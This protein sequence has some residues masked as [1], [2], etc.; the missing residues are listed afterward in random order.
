MC[1]RH[2]SCTAGAIHA[3][4]LAIHARV[5]RWAISARVPRVVNSAL[6]LPTVACM[7]TTSQSHFAKARVLGVYAHPNS[8][9]RTP[10]SELRICVSNAFYLR[11]STK[12][13]AASA[14]IAPSAHAV[15]TC[16]I[17]FLRQSP[18]TKI[19]FVFVVQASSLSA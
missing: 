15:A 12:S 19:P 7:A 11:L 17:L 3:S 18:A 16:L 1:Q 13:H 4:L 8:E 10:N 2:N 5:P 9:F 14:A 6:R